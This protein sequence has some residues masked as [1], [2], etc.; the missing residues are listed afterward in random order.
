[1]PEAHATV[2]RAPPRLGLAVVSMLAA[3]AALSLAGCSSN[4]DLEYVERA[5]EQIYR[6]AQNALVGG[7]YI[8]AA[9]L[10]IGQTLGANISL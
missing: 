8:Q 10:L 2:R 6:E 9:E 4:D 1:M 5:P 3:A 7:N